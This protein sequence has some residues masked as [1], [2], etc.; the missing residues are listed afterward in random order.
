MTG[1]ITSNKTQTLEEMFPEAD[2]KELPLGDN[3]IVQ[4]RSAPKKIGSIYL[5]V[6]TQEVQS[7]AGTVGKVIAVGPLAFHFFSNDEDYKPWP[8]GPWYEV[9]DFVRLPRHGGVRVSSDDVDF[10]V[11]A[12]NQVL[13]KLIDPLKHDNLA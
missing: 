3:I 12:A 4:L 5:S 11:I 2:L 1:L 7:Y 10:V 9:G 13:S 6:E 8:T